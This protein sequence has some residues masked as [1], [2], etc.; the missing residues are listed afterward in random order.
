MWSVLWQEKPAQAVFA[1]VVLLIHARIR[2]LAHFAILQIMYA[3]VRRMLMLVPVEK[4]VLTVLVVL[5]VND[6]PLE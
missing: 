5:L 2:P 4:L 6:D 3:N 1:S